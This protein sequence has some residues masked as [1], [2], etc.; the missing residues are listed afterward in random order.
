MY[1]IWKAYVDIGKNTSE[2]GGNLFSRFMNII[3]YCPTS[4]KKKTKC[5]KAKVNV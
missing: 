2:H 3:V 4:L 1:R 5:R